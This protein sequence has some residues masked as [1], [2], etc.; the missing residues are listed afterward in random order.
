LLFVEYYL[1][2][3]VP[4]RRF[5]CDASFLC[6]IDDVFFFG[7]GADWQQD[8]STGEKLG[9]GRERE[10]KREKVEN[11]EILSSLERK[12]PVENVLTFYM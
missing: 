12:C 8:T 4:D 3:T 6:R 11:R 2:L 9:R 7:R 10:R 1:F 5:V